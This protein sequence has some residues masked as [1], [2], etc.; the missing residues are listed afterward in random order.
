MTLHVCWSPLGK[1][2]PA[3]NRFA[4]NHRLGYVINKKVSHGP[5]KTVACNTS[6]GMHLC[7]IGASLSESHINSTVLV[8]G[9]VYTNAQLAGSLKRCTC[10]ILCVLVCISSICGI[11]CERRKM[12]NHLNW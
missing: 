11:L 12:G 5:T 1:L 10:I 9:S 7:T 8:W 3:N 6:T 4:G 2:K